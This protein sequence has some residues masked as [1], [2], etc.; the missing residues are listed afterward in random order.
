MSTSRGGKKCRPLFVL[1]DTPRHRRAQV[2]DDAH[3][4]LPALDKVLDQHRLVEPLEEAAEL[5]PQLGLVVDDGFGADAH[6]CSFA[7]GLDKEWK[8]QVGID[9]LRKALEHLE[10]RR[11]QAVIG[12]HALGH[13]L[14]QG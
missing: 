2:A 10:G 3:G 6:P 5:R 11:G 1:R 14:V 12:E 9:R 7:A 8:L 4:H 13:R